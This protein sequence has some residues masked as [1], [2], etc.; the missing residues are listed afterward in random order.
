[1]LFRSSSGAFLTTADK[2]AVGCRLTDSNTGKQ[3]YNSG[4]VAVPAWNEVGA[5]TSA[6]VDPLLV[7]VAQVSLT[8]AQI[9]ALFT[10]SIVVIPAVTGKAIIL[11]DLI[12]DLSATATQFTAG[13]VVNLQYK[14]T[15]N[16]AGAALHA[17]IA[18]ATITGATARFIIQRSPLVAGSAITTADIIGQGV[19][20]GAKTQNFA[21]GT[22]TAVVT[23]RYH[24]V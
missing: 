23:A 5:V 20:I 18:A 9:N 7:Q 10:T 3:Y 24:L 22:G 15:A 11:D 12:V 21:T 19:Y 1:V 17:D 16:G 8:A 13:G 6:E 4:T 14:S 2:F